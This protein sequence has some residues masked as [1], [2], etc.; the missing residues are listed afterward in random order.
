MLSLLSC[1]VLPAL[2]ICSSCTVS[3]S[4]QSHVSCWCKTEVSMQISCAARVAHPGLHDLHYHADNAQLYALSGWRAC[5]SQAGTESGV[6]VVQHRCGN[7]SRADH[8]LSSCMAVQPLVWRPRCWAS[9]FCCLCG[10]CMC[11]SIRRPV[12]CCICCRPQTDRVNSST[13][14]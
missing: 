10:C 14:L 2:H 8:W 11:A 13:V 5:N 12:C 6:A 3:G 4:V 7:F 1:S 9:F